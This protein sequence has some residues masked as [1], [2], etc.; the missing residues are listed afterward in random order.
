M[1]EVSAR[2]ANVTVSVNLNQADEAPHLWRDVLKKLDE[3]HADGL[4][5]VAQVAGRSIGVLMCLEGSFHPL[6]FHPAWQEIASLPLREKVKALRN[7]ALRA[8]FREVWR[9]GIQRRWRPFHAWRGGGIVDRTG[10]GFRP[11]NRLQ[12]RRR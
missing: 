7:D 3:A 5:L 4:N 1:R 9:C 11:S 10:R 2:H 12:K 6:A 8:R